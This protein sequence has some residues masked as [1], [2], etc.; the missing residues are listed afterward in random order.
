MRACV[1]LLD[2]VTMPPA[3]KT[4]GV[5]VVIV[6]VIVFFFV[7]QLVPADVGLCVAVALPM[8]SMAAPSALT[9]R[10]TRAT[11]L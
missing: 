4:D 1:A 8:P 5:V 2:G 10:R 3:A 9:G 11:S 7:T 6:V